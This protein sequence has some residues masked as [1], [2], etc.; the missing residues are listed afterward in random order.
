[1]G[2][3]LVSLLRGIWSFFVG[4]LRMILFFG[5][6]FSVL[7]QIIHIYLLIKV[8]SDAHPVEMPTGSVG[9]DDFGLAISLLLLALLG[10]Y[11]TF[12]RHHPSVKAV[13]IQL[14]FSVSLSPEFQINLT[15]NHPH[16]LQFSVLTAVLVT[17]MIVVIIYTMSPGK[18]EQANEKFFGRLH[19][20]IKDYTWNPDSNLEA[21]A[22]W[23]KVQ[24]LMCCGLKGPDDWKKHRPSGFPDDSYPS[25]CCLIPSRKLTGNLFDDNTFTYFCERPNVWETGCQEQVQAI[26]KLSLVFS[27]LFVV[28]HLALAMFAWIVGNCH[29]DPQ[30]PVYQAHSAAH[31]RSGHL[32]TEYQRFE[33]S[34]YVRQQPS[35]E[36]QYTQTAKPHAPSL[37]PNVGDVEKNTYLPPPPSYGTSS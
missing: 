25:S 7:L 33:G 19:N 3:C 15:Q 9:L 21:D 11:G 31:N 30:R 14:P 10:C 1:M 28:F 24:R 34:V 29:L 32:P 2:N 8:T 17:L 35:Y 4:S 6:L 13:S 20:L 5:C 27:Y 12:Y 37:Y 22:T 18:I 23:N 36:Q 16:Q 26:Q